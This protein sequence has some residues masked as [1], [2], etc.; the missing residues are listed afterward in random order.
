M[1]DAKGHFMLILAVTALEKLK[2]VPADFWIKAG[3]GIA[4]FFVAVIVIQK[5]AHVNKMVL[6]AVVFVTCGVLFFSWI[7]ERNEPEFMTPIISAVAPFFPSKGAYQTKQQQEPS[8]P[9]V[10]KNQPPPPPT[11]K[12]Y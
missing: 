12:V 5:V 2:Q 1:Q 10:K 6:G 11:K 3:L 7:Y 9:G 8:T 4:A